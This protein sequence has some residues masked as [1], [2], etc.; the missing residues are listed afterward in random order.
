MLPVPVVPVPVVHVPV[1]YLIKSHYISSETVLYCHD[2]IAKT[3]ESQ[4]YK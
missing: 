2:E 4:E 3:L 1:R